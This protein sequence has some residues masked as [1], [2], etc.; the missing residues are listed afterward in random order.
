MNPKNTSVSPE[1]DD[2]WGDPTGGAEIETSLSEYESRAYKTPEFFINKDVL[3]FK[4]TS[5]TIWTRRRTMYPSSRFL[6]HRL[7]KVASAGR[8]ILNFV[9]EN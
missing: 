8:S 2:Y 9:P 6:S 3:E 1:L 5:R 4:N 7:M